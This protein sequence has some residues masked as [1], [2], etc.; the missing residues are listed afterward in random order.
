MS[1]G[2]TSRHDQ[3]THRVTCGGGEIGRRTRFRCERRKACEFDSH[4]PHQ[5][6]AL[7]KPRAFFYA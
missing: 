5:H 6:K 4:P 7:G 2:L 1:K 3:H